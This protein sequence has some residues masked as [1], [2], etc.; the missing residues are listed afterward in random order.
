MLV[1]AH[2]DAHR[3]DEGLVD[4]DAHAAAAAA[5][6]VSVAEALGLNAALRLERQN[7]YGQQEIQERDHGT[8]LADFV[9]SSTW[10]RFSLPTGVL[11]SPLDADIRLCTP[12]AAP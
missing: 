4:D 3:R 2:I 8:R 11:P 9:R 12:T 6:H 10:M 7:Q 1:A 5:R